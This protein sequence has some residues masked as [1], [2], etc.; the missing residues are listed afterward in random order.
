MTGPAP[1]PITVQGRSSGIDLPE[2]APSLRGVDIDARSQ[3]W[4]DGASD[5]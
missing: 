1:F 5:G 4:L 2:V 3:D